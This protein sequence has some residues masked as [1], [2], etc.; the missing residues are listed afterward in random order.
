MKKCLII[1]Y[2]GKSEYRK[3]LANQ[4][5]EY[6]NQKNIDVIMASSDYM[7]QFDGV[8]NYITLKNVI[9]KTYTT[10]GLYQFSTVNDRMFCQSPSYKNKNINPHNY[11]VKQHQIS[12]NYAK[13]LGYDYYYFLEVDGVIKKSYFDKITADDWDYQKMHLYTFKQKEHYM[14]GFLHG[15]LNI[16]SQILSE[17]NLDYISNLSKTKNVCVTECAYYEMAQK[18]LNDITVHE[19][20]YT[21]VFEQYNT[22]SIRNCAEIFID[23][24]TKSFHYLQFKGDHYNN[25]FS[26]QLFDE[27]NNLLSQYNMKNRGMWATVPLH[28]HR[29]YIIKY[30]EGPLSEEYLSKVSTVY[31]D[32]ENKELHHNWIT[33]IK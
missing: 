9:E 4:M 29:T 19:D 26:A 10:T 23:H 16:A 14:I 21:E 18:H 1:G 17:D 7:P 12:V 22:C 20:E 25:E 11:F 3:Q 30:Y 32:P 15:N 5:I 33:H 31:T 28:N 27:K 13:M 24:S 2:Y 8:K 6:F